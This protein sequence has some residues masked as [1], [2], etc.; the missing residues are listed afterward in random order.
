MKRTL[1]FRAIFYFRTGWSL[2][3]AFVL[4]AINTLTVTYYLAIEKLPI[5]KE[6]FPT[7]GTY[8]MVAVGIG[9]PLLILVGYSHFKKTGAY[10]AEAEVVYEANPFSTRSIVNSELILELQLKVI[11]YVIKSSN[12]EQLTQDELKEMKSLHKEILEHKQ[13]RTFANKKDVKYLKN[14]LGE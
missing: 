11:Q 5:L 14:K 4:A 9:V 10:K 6:V 1:P 8:L 3:F 7:F 2:Y 13:K 12:N